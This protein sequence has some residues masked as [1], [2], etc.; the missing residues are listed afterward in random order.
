MIHTLRRY[1]TGIFA[2]LLTASSL[3][4]LTRLAGTTTVNSL[5]TTE[6]WYS[7]ALD[8]TVEDTEEELIQPEQEK[9]EQVLPDSVAVVTDGANVRITPGVKEGNIAQTLSKGDQAEVTGQKTVDGTVWYEI[10]SPNDNQ[11]LWISSKAVK[12]Y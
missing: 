7:Q 5:K 9:Q 6:G 4:I 1:S 11:K 12:A 3:F 2:L 10:I 8:L